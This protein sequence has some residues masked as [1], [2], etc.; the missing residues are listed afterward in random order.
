[1]TLLNKKSTH[2][3]I[4]ILGLV[5]L[6][7][8][9]GNIVY[10][11][12][13]ISRLNSADNSLKYKL[14]F[15]DKYSIT[16]NVSGK[17]L[18][19]P[20][21][22]NEDKSGAP[23]L[24]S[25]IVY[26][27]I[28]PESKILINLT[29]QKYVN[30][31]DTK[32]AVNPAVKILN[33]TTLLY[34]VQSMKRIYFISD[35]YP[36]KEYEIIGYTWI[37]NYYCAEIKINTAFYNWKTR[38]TKILISTEL[39]ATY[40]SVSAYRINN[41]QESIYDKILKKII[42]N[43]DDAKTF[44][45]YRKLY[46]YRDTTGNWIDYSKQYVKLK[47]PADGIYRISYNDLINY[48]VYP[49]DIDPSTLKLYCKGK[50]LP[51]YIKSDGSKTLSVGDYMEFW[52]TKN[53][54]SP[55]YRKIVSFGSDYLN[56]MNRYSDTTV[57]WLT[58]GGTNGRRI[59]ISDTKTNGIS[60][61]LKSYL[62]RQHFEKDIRLW[63]YDSAI[64]RVQLPFWQENKVW[65]WAV[66][67][68]GG[69][70]SLPFT[71]SDVVPG[72]KFNTIVRLISNGA[73]IQLNAHKIGIGINSN[74]VSDTITFNYKQTIN[75]E[76]NFSSNILNGGSNTLKLT[77]LPT[78]GTFQQVLLDWI[79]I[80]YYRK[81]VAVKD[82]LYFGFPDSLSKKL[83]VIKI[84]NI[85]PDSTFILFKISP[86]TE[87]IESY[88]IV[89]NSTNAIVFSDT[90]SG[91]DKY[92]LITPHYVKSP[93]FEEKKKF[94][95]LRKPE[96]GADDIIISNKLLQ[97]SVV[98]Y[99]DFIKNN[100]NVRTSLIYVNDIYDEFSFGY[101]QPEA[102][103]RFLLYAYNNWT[104]PSP[105]Y[106]TLIGDANYDYKNLWSPVPPVRKQDLVPAYGDPVSDNW[107]C[108][109]DTAMADIP[110]MLVGRIPAANN[111]QVNFYLDKYRKYLQKPYDDWNKTFLFFS[112]GDPT[113]PSQLDQLKSVNDSV[114]HNLVQPKP[115]GGK[116]INFYKTINP[117]TNYGPYS[118]SK[119]QS[120]IDNGA[121]FISYLGH[122]GTQTWDNGVTDVSDLK[123]LF[124]NR[125]PLITD[126]GCSTGKFAEPDVN[127][128]G[129]L[130]ISESDQGRLSAIWAMQVG[131]I[132]L[133]P[134]QYLCISTIIF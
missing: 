64:P 101:A 128:F 1:M 89:N 45:S 40:N 88:S 5:L 37:R 61:T 86:D 60:D 114:L 108:T 57:A 41:S 69:S 13:N 134:F 54:G 26:F 21:S 116:G 93:V 52:A 96:L 17:Y 131:A 80:E 7:F 94:I 70:F 32:I 10:A 112:G 66:L 14:L 65:T 28:P 106:L 91:G 72:S 100:Y 104:A 53:Y 122:S 109:W 55:E 4:T 67:G 87:K 132:Y 22:M 25:K 48:G 75:F 16:N 129:E 84:S 6:L 35:Q 83:R 47:I 125:F 82:S 77:G 71:S 103:R 85:D 90:V 19:F 115:I 33:D 27:A 58:W 44:R 39:N 118:N 81:L 107:Y 18:D 15:K 29:N 62:N 12:Y 36:A 46:G 74:S 34:N 117:S 23:I 2:S 11:Q 98:K 38:Q 20:N 31:S 79:D 113:I 76:S 102:I 59:K 3:Y 50:E 105:S 43:Y 68:T 42:I 123:N 56:Y 63:Y 97:Q 130:F 99:D 119:I 120:S 95:D 24:P 124:D 111:A 110:Q 51:L 121:L 49:S 9:K 133:L 92:I 126:F 30:I 127:A 78:P 73:D 8:L